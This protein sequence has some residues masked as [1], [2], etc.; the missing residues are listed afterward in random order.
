MEFFV[1]FTNSDHFVK[2]ELG[3][4]IGLENYKMEGLNREHA[5][6][7]DMDWEPKLL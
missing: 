6:Q 5:M 1:L 7:S 2:L 4:Y 3:D